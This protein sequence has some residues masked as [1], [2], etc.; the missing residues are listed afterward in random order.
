MIRCLIVVCLYSINHLF[1]QYNLVPNPSFETC[2]NCPNYG[3]IGEQFTPN[4]V[5]LANWDNPGGGNPDYLNCVTPSLHAQDGSAFVGIG[6]YVSPYMEL[7]Y[8]NAR[9]YLQCEL[10]DSLIF[11]EKYLVKFFTLTGVLSNNSPGNFA[12]NNI[13]LHF[14]D[15]LLHTNNEYVIPL[16]SQVKYFNNEI[17]SDTSTWT[18]VSGI[19]E[20]E[21]GEKFMTVGNF[22]FDS[23]TNFICFFPFWPAAGCGH[24]WFDNFSVTP[25]DSI[26]G[27]LQVNAGQ[28]YSI[29]PGDTAFIGEKISNLPA[30]WY[31]LDGTIVDTNTAGVY[32]HPSVTTTYVVTMTINGVYS[33]DTVTVTV[34]CAG[35]D[36]LEKPSFR[37]GP[38]PNDGQF[39]INGQFSEGDIIS[40]ISTEG[41]LMHTLLINQQTDIQLINLKL[42]SGTY[43]L[44]IQNDSRKSLY[45]TSVL[46]LDK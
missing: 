46:I 42:K 36:E 9:E 28:D 40:I 44:E 38:N 18:K 35:V 23:E 8:H 31:L 29:C 2:Y 39:T 34:G 14:S 30:N 17:I 33:T 45:R 25:L 1:G 41:R 32:V 37:I 43:F 10:T 24:V 4:N 16:I 11:N 7:Q 22:N 3:V 19:Y 27:G 6:T 21:G 13:G 20:A 12:S 26:P 15:T 5:I